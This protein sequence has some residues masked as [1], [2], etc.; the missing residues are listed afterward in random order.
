MDNETAH[1]LIAG[2]TAKNHLFVIEA[3]EKAG[4][5]AHY[6]ATISQ[7][8]KFL[9]K[10]SM[11]AILLDFDLGRNAVMTFLKKT[12]ESD[13]AV[14]VIVVASEGSIQTVAEALQLNAFDFLAR[15]LGE[16]QLIHVLKQA[17]GAGRRR[18][19]GKTTTD[20]TGASIAIVGQS[21]AMVEVYKSIVRVSKTDSTVLI[22][23]ESGTGKEL[24]AKAI[25]QF[26]SRN[27]K[28]FVP[29][30]C[31]A[32]TETLLESELFGHAKGSFSGA[33]RDHQGIF[34]TATGGTVFLDEISETSPTFQVK[35]LRVLQERSIKPVGAPR[36]KAVD[37][38][39]ISATNQVRGNMFQSS[40]RKDLLYRISV[41]HIHIPALRERIE[42]IPLLAKRFLRTANKRQH[43]HATIP[44]KTLQWMK[45]QPWRGNVRELEN[46]IER[47][48]TMNLSGE[49]QPEDLIQLNFQPDNPVSVD[50]FESS[51]PTPLSPD[52][53]SQSL[54]SLDDVARD[55]IL[56]VLKH[57]KGSKLRA[58]RILGIA[59]PSLYRMAKRLGIDL[60]AAVLNAK[61]KAK[62]N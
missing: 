18:K 36:E 10:S 53:K 32:L 21:P 20:S 31:G 37:V 52:A 51:I 44:P 3:L 58:A 41:I 7:A 61:R 54:G 26:S 15:P 6:A 12:G 46:V 59:R 19:L 38:R 50:Q 56:K 48:V 57:T 45:S 2:S 17:V 30:N 60:D 29:V 43:K 14:P 5:E 49:I 47:A 4:I 11:D 1:V 25:H 33:L 22:T 23:G 34:E 62:D 42:D 39:V 8:N 28:P 55:H 27:S 40:F 16:M 35:L 9:S 13:N 24:A